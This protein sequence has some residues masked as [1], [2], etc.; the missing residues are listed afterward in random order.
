MPSGYPFGME[1][2]R[3]FFDLICSG[4]PIS[5]AAKLAGVSETR[6]FQWWANAGPMTT[7][8]A[9]GGSWSTFSCRPDQPG[10]R[11][12]RLNLVERIAIMRGRDADR[13]YGAIARSIGRDKSVIR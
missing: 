4:T 3:E 13:S 6:A 12:H 2:R 10:G 7:T 11:G 1:K 9:L 5:R 8:R